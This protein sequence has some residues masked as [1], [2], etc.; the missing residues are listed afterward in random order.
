MS[1][2]LRMLGDIKSRILSGEYPPGYRLPTEM[3]LCHQYDC[4]RMTASKVLSELAKS[5]LIE[6]RKRA[7]SFV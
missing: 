2:H 4:S 1:L 7:G 3:D 5:G 6:R